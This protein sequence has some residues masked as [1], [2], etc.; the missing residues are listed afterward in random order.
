MD[1]WKTPRFMSKLSPHDRDVVLKAFRKINDAVNNGM[2]AELF[3]AKQL[4]GE[5]FMKSL[6]EM[7]R[8][9]M[10]QD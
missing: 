3:L 9:C 2:D 10:P 1:A 5:I 7:I 8:E 6:D 4:N